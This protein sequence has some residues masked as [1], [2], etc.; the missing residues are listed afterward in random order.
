MNLCCVKIKYFSPSLSLS[1]SSSIPLCLSLPFCSSFFWGRNPLDVYPS[2]IEI[3]QWT[4]SASALNVLEAVNIRRICK[5]LISYMKVGGRPL[6]LG[7]C[8][9]MILNK[10]FG[11]CYDMVHCCGINITI[12]I[13]AFHMSLCI[14]YTRCCRARHA[15]GIKP[16]WIYKT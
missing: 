14:R 9:V 1:L 16:V 12:G 13:Y 8:C 15:S 5:Q 7:I 2:Q 6:C 4:Y 11:V 3:N 10:H